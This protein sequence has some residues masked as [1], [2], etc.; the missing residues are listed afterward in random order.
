MLQLAKKFF[1]SANERQLKPFRAR[2][3][4]INAL[5][6]VIEALS[7]EA[8]RAKTQEFKTALANG[9]TLDSILEEAFAVVREGSKRSGLNFTFAKHIGTPRTKRLKRALWGINTRHRVC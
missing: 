8:L 1:G 3:Q 4:R 5:E 9:A 6:P 2:V 7:D